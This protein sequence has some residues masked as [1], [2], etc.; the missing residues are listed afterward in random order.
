M[1]ARNVVQTVVVVVIFILCGG[2]LAVGCQGVREAAARTQCKNNLRHLSMAVHGYHDTYG[3][4]PPAGV[5]KLSLPPERR[6]SWFVGIGPFVEAT[7]LY[8]MV[9]R[10]KGWDAEENR[11]AALME[12]PYLRCP[13]YP[14]RPPESTLA[15]SHYLGIPGVGAD[16]VWLPREDPAAGVF[17][18]ERRARLAD[19]SGRTDKV[20]VAVETSRAGGAWTAAPASVRGPDPGD[21]PYLGRDRPFGGNHRGGANA[22]FA[23]GSAQFLGEGLDPGVFESLATLGGRTGAEGR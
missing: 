19:I 7:N 2:M 17:G 21:R 10:E 11:F 9:D 23:D 3:A 14:E 4:F 12:L 1:S 22:V 15:P 8:A 16:A 20:L 13:A 6:L 5:P 18:Y